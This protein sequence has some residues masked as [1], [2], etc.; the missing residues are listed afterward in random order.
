MKKTTRYAIQIF[1]V[2]FLVTI[3]LFGCTAVS[4]PG[5]DIMQPSSDKQDS[6][7]QD[8]ATDSNIKDEIDQ[9]N[10]PQNNPVPDQHNLQK[11][12]INYQLWQGHDMVLTKMGTLLD[13][14]SHE[15]MIFCFDPLCNHKSYDKCPHLWLKYSLN[16]FGITTDEDGGLVMYMYARRWGKDTS[17]YEDGSMIYDFIS[18]HQATQTKEVLIKEIKQVGAA[19]SLDSNTNTIYHMAYLVGDDGKQQ[20]GFYALNVETKENVLLC[21]VPEM[22]SATYIDGDSL[23]ATSITGRLYCI[24]LLPNGEGC[25]Q[26]ELSKDCAFSSID[27][28]YLY[29][30]RKQGE[31]TVSVPDELIE[32]SQN[33][34]VPIS[35]TFAYYNLY[36]TD[37]DSP[38]E[39]GEL[40]VENIA[41]GGVS[42]GYLTYVEFEPRYCESMLRS[43]TTAN[44]FFSLDDPKGANNT[45]LEHIFTANGARH[46]IRMDTGETVMT[47]DLEEYQLGGY[48]WEWNRKYWLAD[49]QNITLEGRQRL[50][51]EGKPFSRLCIVPQKSDHSVI[52]DEDLVF[53]DL[54]K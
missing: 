43:N 22:M 7:K 53:Y 46:V 18:Y 14:N 25:Q 38:E 27:S 26:V 8:S 47:I 50:Y 30:L 29:Y 28:G 34:K 17:R 44:L 32:R 42:G 40:I 19:W 13:I 24:D 23:Y 16:F 3:L 20:L 37:I 2:L 31:V 9:S 21:T 54:M 33:M 15:E 48:D 10:T 39:E 11:S 45:R 51:S 1:L 4:A 12:T 49:A 6:D 35:K 41:S 52:T 5:K 36:R